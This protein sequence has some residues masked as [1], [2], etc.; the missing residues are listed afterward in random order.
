MC[1]EELDERYAT[2]R[3]HSDEFRLPRDLRVTDREARRKGP[4]LVLNARSLA[5]RRILR[6]SESSAGIVT[7]KTDIR[8]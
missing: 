1:C 4:C 2:A 5:L 6:S 7:L 3:N 8:S